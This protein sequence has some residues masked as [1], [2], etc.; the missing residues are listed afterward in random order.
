M[1]KAVATKALANP[2][3]DVPDHPLQVLV[4]PHPQIQV[5]D[6]LRPGVNPEVIVRG[7]T[8]LP[9]RNHL[10]KTEGNPSFV[11]GH[12]RRRQQQG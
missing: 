7:K 10:G 3:T 4:I 1:G 9:R 6:I 2:E 11:Q 12:R 8:A 5:S